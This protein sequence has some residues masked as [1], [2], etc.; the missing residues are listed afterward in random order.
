MTT[1]KMGPGDEDDEYDEDNGGIAGDEDEDD[2][3]YDGD[4]TGLI[5]ENLGD[6]GIETLGT[7]V[8]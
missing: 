2:T 5:G 6:D 8:R 7:E 1:I 3:V 4:E